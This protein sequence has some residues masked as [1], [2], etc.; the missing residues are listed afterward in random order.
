MTHKEKRCTHCK[1]RYY[2]QA[3]GEGCGDD[4]NDDRYC[5]ECMQ[6]ITD[7][8]KKVPIKIER[9]DVRVEDSEVSIN[10]LL[11]HEQ[12][13]NILEKQRNGERCFPLMK[14]VYPSLWDCLDLENRNHCRL[15]EYNSI[16]YYVSTWSKS[17]ENNYVSKEV[18]YDLINNKIIGN[19]VKLG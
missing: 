8:L 1:I 17:P 7:A 5:P 9:R 14:S 11:I 13:K 18:E 10:D 4:Y 6:I 2:Y 19:W 15:I 3:S 16:N 12:N